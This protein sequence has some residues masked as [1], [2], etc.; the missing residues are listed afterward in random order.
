MKLKLIINELESPDDYKLLQ[1]T[2]STVASLR[3]TAVLRFTEDKLVIISTPKTTTS[4][5][6][7][8]TVLQG[9]T[10]QLWCS[11]P[12]DVFSLYDV[13]SVRDLNTITMEYSCDTLLAAFK[14]YDKIMSQGSSS[15]MN[16]K[17]LSAPEWNKTARSRNSDELGV[18]TN[19]L[20]ALSITFEEIV[21][22]NNSVNSN[23][24]QD[25][26]NQSGSNYSRIS[27]SNKVIMHNF[28]VPVKLLF[29]KQDIAIQEPMVNYTQLMMY[30][31]PPVSGP[32][33]LAFHNFLR[34]IERYSNVQNLQLRSIRRLNQDDRMV[35]E[36]GRESDLKILVDELHWNLEICWN[37]P[38][39]PVIQKTDV[40][41]DDE[42]EIPQT[43]P[44][45]NLPR[46][47]SN[48]PDR[49]NTPRED[50]D[51]ML[52]DDSDMVDRRETSYVTNDIVDD[53]SRD[54]ENIAVMVERAERESNLIHDVIIKAR[55]WKVCS[56]LYPAFEDIILAISHDESCVFHCSL[57]RGPAENAD[58]SEDMK[59]KG[60]IIYY[61][62]R[63]KGL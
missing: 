45:L 50:E 58:D 19:P 61:M 33:G 54:V 25:D 8:S 11:I 52:I 22:I 29:K 14:R 42:N 28:K 36:S 24:P 46:S 15:S 6:S 59:Q 18:V 32:F 30:K 1:T 39:D 48:V 7:S 38:L 44:S 5:L 26:Y 35:D 53:R 12:K 57:D 49:D 63:S 3:K 27:G 37:G 13:K 41:V 62:A 10:G 9:D 47:I 34:R 51:M 55:D 43:L 17:L 21:Y 4:G 56:K 31:L 40:D 23:N 60:Q 16:I 20:G 2:V